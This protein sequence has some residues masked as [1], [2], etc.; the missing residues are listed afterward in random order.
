MHCKRRS[1][2][3]ASAHAAGAAYLRLHDLERVL[4]ELNCIVAEPLLPPHLCQVVHRVGGLAARRERERCGYEWGGGWV[5]AGCGKCG[6]SGDAPRDRFR[7]HSALRCDCHT[8]AGHGSACVPRTA[9]HHP[10]PW[11]SYTTACGCATRRQCREA[12]SRAAGAAAG[13]RLCP[14]PR[15]SSFIFSACS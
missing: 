6:R 12:H 13:A 5:L 3:C 7:P 8:A 15:T 14:V 9:R 2:S 1:N 10:Q 11:A 4:H